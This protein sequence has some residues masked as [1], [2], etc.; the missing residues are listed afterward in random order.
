MVN[1]SLFFANKLEPNLA[2]LDYNMS[3]SV[4]EIY[5]I[6]TKCNQPKHV[7]GFFKKTIEPNEL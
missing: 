2:N 6:M 4:C 1:I 7:D 5:I 3:D